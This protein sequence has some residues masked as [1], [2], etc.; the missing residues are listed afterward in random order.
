MLVFCFIPPDC[1]IKYS[2]VSNTLNSQF[3]IQTLLCLYFF[4]FFHMQW[5]SGFRKNKI[6]IIIIIIIKY[7]YSR[8]MDLWKTCISS[9]CHI[10]KRSFLSISIF[11]FLQYLLLLL[12]SSRSC[13]LLLPTP[14]SSVICP[15]RKSV[16]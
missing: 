7:T 4:Q 10:D 5:T 13:V 16:V 9:L 3:L 2:F 6:I 14:F 15:D 1:R 12:K 8:S 11:S